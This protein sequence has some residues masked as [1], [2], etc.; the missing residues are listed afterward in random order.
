MIDLEALREKRVIYV[1]G[2]SGS[3]KSVFAAALAAALPGYNL[4][5]LDWIY[6][7]LHAARTHGG[8]KRSRRVMA[9]I[10]PKIVAEIVADG[11]RRIIEG[12]WVEPR[13][14]QRLAAGD[15]SVYAIFLGYPDTN[16][17]AMAERLAATTHW[18]SGDSVENHTFIADQIEHSKRLRRKLGG[19]AGIDFIDVSAGWLDSL[20]A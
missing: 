15:P 13:A 10:A 12:G 6:S 1:G 5:K 7:G 19:R 18:L 20:P 2:V 8:V 4:I 9:R 11:G 16:V 17:A 3:G 14:W